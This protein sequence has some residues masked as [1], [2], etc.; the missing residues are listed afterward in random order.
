MA[1]PGNFGEL[2]AEYPLNERQAVRPLPD[3]RLAVYAPCTNLM[4]AVRWALGWGGDAE[5]LAPTALRAAVTREA[6]AM[7]ARYR[8][9]DEA[10]GLLT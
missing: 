4:G 2:L 10:T 9:G 1:F 7:S 8:T 6:L 5:A 3:G